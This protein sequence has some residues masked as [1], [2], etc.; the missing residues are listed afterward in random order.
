MKQRWLYALL[1]T[2]I[3]VFSLGAW[4]QN[5]DGGSAAASPGADAPFEFGMHIGNLLPNQ[6][7]GVTEI[8]GLGG[9]RMGFRLSPGSY[10]EG[11][12]ITGNGSGQQWKNAHVDVRM[13]VPV[14]NL[15]GMAYIGADS[16]YYK[17]T[18]GGSRLIFGG[19]VGG[20]VMAHLSGSAWFRG[21]MKFG[22]SPGTSLYFGF[23]IVWR[24][25]SGG[26][27]GA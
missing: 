21:D 16:V 27:G 23:G 25:G 17:G 26:G 5:E 14:E 3:S 4:A 2:G 11:G 10:L 9:A 18:S 7:A 12:F 15:L 22:F 24:L 20:G 6:I 13:D 19:H 8:M 1:L